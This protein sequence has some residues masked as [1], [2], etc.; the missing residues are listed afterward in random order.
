MSKIITSVLLMMLAASAQATDSKYEY[1]GNEC[2][3]KYH[4]IWESTGSQPLAANFQAAC[5]LGLQAGIDGD[6]QQQREAA[7]TIAA[8]SKDAETGMGDE[9]AMLAVAQ[10]QLF[11]HEYERAWKA[12]H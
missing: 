6:E 2:V 10:S 8:N 9:S 5:Y 1:L 3:A 7:E 12:A 4:A 11:L